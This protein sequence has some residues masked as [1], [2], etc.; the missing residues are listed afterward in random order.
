MG[1]ASSDLGMRLGLS[2]K[3]VVEKVFG[4]DAPHALGIQGPRGLDLF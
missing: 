3:P 1:Y 4:L 2:E